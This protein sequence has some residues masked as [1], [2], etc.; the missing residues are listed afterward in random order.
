MRPSKHGLN[1]I[2]TGIT[3]WYGRNDNKIAE[4]AKNGLKG[5]KPTIKQGPAL[6]RNKLI[7]NGK[8]ENSSRHTRLKI[9]G[10][11]HR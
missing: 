3:E 11:M 9:S 4:G 2:T 10:R 6:E 5:G 1:D 7:K 8:L